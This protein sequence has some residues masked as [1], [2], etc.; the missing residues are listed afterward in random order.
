ME[1]IIKAVLSDGIAYGKI[2]RIKFNHHDVLDSYTIADVKNAINLAISN[3]DKMKTANDDLN[4]Y[5]E[6]QKLILLDKYLIEKIT[7]LMNNYKAI[8]AI[9]IVIDEYIKNI[10]ESSSLYLKERANDLID[11][12]NQIIHNLIGNS[13]NNN[14]QPQILVLDEL[15]PTILINRLENVIGV[16]AKKGGFTSHSAILCR[17]EGIPFVLVDDDIKGET[18]VIDT[19]RRIIITEPNSFEINRINEIK[20]LEEAYT[21]KAINHPNYKF[22]AN[23]SSNADVKKA[24]DYGF[25]GV[26][27]YRTEFI[28]INNERPLSI[29]DQYNIYSNAIK[30]VKDKSIAFRSFDVGDDKKITY[31]T[32]NK[33]GIENYYNYPDLFIS[34]INALLKASTDNNKKIKLLFPMIRTIKEFNDLKEW[35]LDICNTNNYLIPKIGMML[36]TKDAIENINTFTSVDFISV[37]TNDLTQE[38]YNFDRMTELNNSQLYID[39]LLARLAKVITF[40]NANNIELCVC[41]ELASVKEIALE[42]YRIGIKDISVSPQL[43]KHLNICYKEFTSE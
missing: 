40:T 26:G 38:L 31:I 19:R 11:I 41:G 28:F 16:I 5:I 2:E 43:I 17:A 10:N 30:L 34:Q 4:N 6:I 25:D 32:S 20:T 14:N 1:Y 37:G 42:L 15:F 39:D 21:Y 8:D 13:F 3:L 27:L 22:Y 7:N 33:K 23:C 24:M 35:V 29:E 36:E 12:K 9:N 18:V